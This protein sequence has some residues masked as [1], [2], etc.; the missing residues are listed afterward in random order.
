[1]IANA[2]IQSKPII[3]CNDNFC[4]TINYTRAEVMQKACTCEFLYGT[5]TSQTS[6]VQIKQA[7]TRTEETQ[8]IILLYKKDGKFF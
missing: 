4:E 7:L 8:V 2:L 6:K 1:M 5:L 3:Y